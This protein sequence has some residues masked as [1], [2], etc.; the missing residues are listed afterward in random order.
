[1]MI[2][3]KL[4]FGTDQAV[5]GVA[6][7]STDIYDQRNTVERADDTMTVEFHVTEAFASGTSLALEVMEGPLSTRVGETVAV[8][9]SVLVADLTEGAM[10]HIQLPRKML[11][12]LGVRYTPTGTFDAGT[13]SAYLVDKPQTQGYE[14]TVEYKAIDNSGR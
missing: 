13:I 2:D 3:K 12:Y 1:M 4:R 11:R 5:L 10:F 8:S 9:K 14:A 7:Q 6:V